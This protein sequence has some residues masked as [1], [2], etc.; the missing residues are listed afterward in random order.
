[1]AKKSKSAYEYMN[2]ISID[3]YLKCPICTDPFLDPV[4]TPCK[5]TFCRRCIVTWL[6]LHKTSCP[7]CREIL[8]KED[9][10]SISVIF[11][12][13][14]LN[15]ILVKCTLCDEINLQ[16]G[17][18]QN[19]INNL[20]PKADVSCSINN[21]TSCSW[22]GSRDQLEI[23]QSKCKIYQ[24]KLMSN[25]NC[26]KDQRSKTLTVDRKENVVNES[27]NPRELE[28]E[29][30]II[31]SADWLIELSERLMINSDM[32]IVV[33]QAIIRKQ[34]T[35]LILSENHIDAS[36]A[37]ILAKA[38]SNNTSLI[39]LELQYDCIGDRGV[40]YLADALSVNKCL[41]VLDLRDN[42]ITHEGARH[43]ANMLKKNQTLTSLLLNSNHIDDRG[44]RLLADALIDN[45][46][47]RQLSLFQTKEIR[48]RREEDEFAENDLR[49]F[50]EKINKLRQS[51]E[52]LNQPNN[53]KVI[54]SQ[55][56][57]VDWNR[58][59]SVEKQQERVVL[60]SS[61]IDIGATWSPNGT[62]VAGDSEQGN[63]LNQL[64]SPQGICVDNEDQVVYIADWCNH[65]IMKWKFDLTD[66]EIVAGGNG[67]GNRMDQLNN[68]LDVIIDKETD[69]LI[70][71]DSGNQRVVQWPCRNASRGQT[72]ISNI[73]CRGLAM[74]DN[75]F[76]YVSNYNKSEVQ[77]WRIGDSQGTVVAGGNGKGIHLNQLNGPQYV[78]VD[79]DH[80][81]YISDMNNYRV[82]KWLQGAQEGII[83]AG[84]QGKGNTL[85]QL[86]SPYGVIVDPLGTVYV[87]DC[88]NHQIV[89]WSNGAKEG[90]VIVGGNGCGN[91]PNQLNYPVGFSFDQYG[92]LYVS[93]NGNSRIQLFNINTNSR[94]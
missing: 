52:R 32:S 23:H 38:L 19:H 41:K 72:I 34:C 93:D 30:Y 50:Q 59:I 55:I 24:S 74:D 17:N 80:S 36:G 33:E 68:P 35:I 1:M 20:C 87:A 76:L 21:D 45:T 89:R 3:N 57:Q 7:S 53:I 63:R 67:A 64:N 49:Q 86:S 69:N 54:T 10:T 8:S 61:H 75:R 6:E 82:M 37:L 40:D 62:T 83:V 81:V 65:R 9:L 42:N 66:G 78:F 85:S 43:L 71:C 14:M 29:D 94:S 22:I 92:N 12:H 73:D 60:R 26:I 77:R 11:I 2:E 4:S 15:E 27:T 79:Q 25:T 48:S 18:F 70:I 90:T 44:V 47:L 88:G 91:K 5:H 84:G 51:F 56:G 58:L 16:R 28:L 46:S 39:R 13:G 31:R